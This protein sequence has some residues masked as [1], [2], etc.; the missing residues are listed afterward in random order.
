MDVTYFTYEKIIS[1]VRCHSGPRMILM[2]ILKNTMSKYPDSMKWDIQEMDA[3][4]VDLGLTLK[5]H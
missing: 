3:C 4:I 5:I 1:L 2:N